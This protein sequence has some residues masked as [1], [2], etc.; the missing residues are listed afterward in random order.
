MDYENRDVVDLEEKLEWVGNNRDTGGDRVSQK[1]LVWLG[2]ILG[3][4]FLDE[5]VFF[6]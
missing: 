6:D 5:I 3:N 1:V 4:T 2:K